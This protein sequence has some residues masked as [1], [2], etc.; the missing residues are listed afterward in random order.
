V[1]TETINEVTR[2]DAVDLVTFT[3]F[4]IR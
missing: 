2:I 3:R 1:I 4:S